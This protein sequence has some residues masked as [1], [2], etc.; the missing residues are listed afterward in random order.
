MPL[1][2]AAAEI[3]GAPGDPLLEVGEDG[4]RKLSARR[5]LRERI[6][7]GENLE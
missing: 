3:G 2:S 5:H 1:Y 7:I 4:C 6:A